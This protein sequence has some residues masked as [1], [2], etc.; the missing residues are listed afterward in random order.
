MVEPEKGA[1]GN[2]I[3][4]TRFA[5]WITQAEKH[6]PEYVILIVFHG[7]N[8]YTVRLSVTSYV[9]CLSCISWMV[10]LAVAIAWNREMMNELERM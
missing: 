2:I 7:N 10:Y 5:C 3:R 6:T 1:D 8:G 9:H 4:Q